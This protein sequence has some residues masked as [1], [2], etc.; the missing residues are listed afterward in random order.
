MG[1]L[2]S[3]L[4]WTRGEM[5]SFS[6]LRVGGF[7]ERLWNSY[8]W[9]HKKMVSF[10]SM[11]RVKYHRENLE[12]LLRIRISI[13]TFWKM[14]TYFGRIIL[15]PVSRL[16]QE[17]PTSDQRPSVSVFPDRARRRAI[18]I[19]GVQRTWNEAPTFI[20]SLCCSTLDLHKEKQRARKAFEL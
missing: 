13:T 3:T 8:T 18:I 10:C 17:S 6:V 12:I 4:R 15:C 16:T 1:I 11:A 14:S 5:R 7:W 20:E 2:S 9:G 19:Q